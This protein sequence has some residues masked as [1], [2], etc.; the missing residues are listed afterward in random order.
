MHSYNIAKGVKVYVFMYYRFIYIIIGLKCYSG[1]GTVG[2]CYLGTIYPATL[3]SHFAA[4]RHV[5]TTFS[6]TL[7]DKEYNDLHTQNV[8]QSKPNGTGVYCSYKEG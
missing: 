8:P 3:F 1:V 7:S 5:T 2:I 6:Y 4:R